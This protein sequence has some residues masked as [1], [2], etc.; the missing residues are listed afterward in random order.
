MQS[1]VDVSREPD[2]RL[3]GRVVLPRRRLDFAGN[4]DL[5]RVLEGPDL[6]RRHPPLRQ[7]LASEA[8]PRRVGGEPWLRQRPPSR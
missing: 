8:V 4:L 2:S 3:E 6:A 5:H 1:I 7:P